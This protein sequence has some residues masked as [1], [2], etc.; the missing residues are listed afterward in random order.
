MQTQRRY[1]TTGSRDSQFVGV[2]TSLHGRPHPSAQIAPAGRPHP[3]A[4]CT[5][6]QRTEIAP[7][8]LHP[9]PCTHSPL[10]RASAN[11]ESPRWPASVP[12]LACY[13][14][15][16]IAPAGR[17]HPFPSCTEPQRTNSGRW[18]AASVPS[19]QATPQRTEKAPAEAASVPLLAGCTPA[20]RKPLLACCIRSLHPI[21]CC[22]EPQRTEKAPAG[23]LH[24]FPASV[25]QL[26]PS[27]QI[28]PAEAASLHPLPN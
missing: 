4:C 14:S 28:A 13:P 12:L 11:R 3:I 20:H 21:A 25:P 16:Q 26:H 27:Q 18:Q 22:I 23:L 7:A 19:W 1:S 24:P 8:G 9:F 6:P 15:A 5:E 10:H 17:L 2:G